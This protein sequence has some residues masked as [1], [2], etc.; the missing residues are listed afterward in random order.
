MMAATYIRDDGDDHMPTYRI[1][2]GDDEQVIRETFT[3]VEVQR[4]SGCRHRRVM[5]GHPIKAPQRQRS[6]DVG[7]PR[8][9][10]RQACT[11][12]PVSSHYA[13]R[14]DVCQKRRRAAQLDLRVSEEIG[15]I[16]RRSLGRGS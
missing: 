9:G 14:H 11:S 3:D 1:V 10:L 4:I 5:A 2:Y 16:P 13:W 6:F 7:Y 12:K 8:G 15:R